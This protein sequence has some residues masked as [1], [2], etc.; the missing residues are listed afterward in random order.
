M[1]PEYQVKDDSS[2]PRVFIGPSFSFLLEF[3]NLN[4][5]RRAEEGYLRDGV[6]NTH[7]E[8]A[9]R[10]LQKDSSA[11]IRALLRGIANVWE[12]ER[13][14]LPVEIPGNLKLPAVKVVSS[15]APLNLGKDNK[16]VMIYASSAA[17]A[18][19]EHSLAQVTRP[20]PVILILEDQEQH[21]EGFA[22]S[23]TA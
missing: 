16:A 4:R 2:Q 15:L 6:K 10:E 11:R 3:N 23:H 7:L 18:D 5:I 17:E 20:M 22:F 12:M 19:L 1:D 14:P 13:A 9:F 8:E 21:I